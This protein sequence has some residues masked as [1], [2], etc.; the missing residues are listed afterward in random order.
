M[1]SHLIRS[2]L[3]P[4]L[5]GYLILMVILAVGLRVQRRRTAAG[6]PLT[7]LTGRRDRGWPALILHALT[8]AL[9]GYLVLAA[10]VVLYYYGVAKVGGSFLDS[11]FTGTALL[12]AI[13]LPVFFLVSWLT[14]RRQA[15]RKRDRQGS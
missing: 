5:S 9:A 14:Q 6:H 15:Q 10:V 11:A 2:D 3:V 4:I 13:S 1:S 12:L 7:R 8:D